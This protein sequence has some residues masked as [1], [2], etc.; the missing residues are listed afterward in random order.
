MA[1]ISVRVSK[2]EQFAS[3]SSV[4]TPLCNTGGVSGISRPRGLTKTQDPAPQATSIDTF[5]I[6]AL[7]KVT[8]IKTLLYNLIP[9][10]EFHRRE[11]PKNYEFGEQFVLN[12]EILGWIGFG[13]GS[14]RIFLY[15]TG[16]GCRFF[17]KQGFENIERA[18]KNLTGARYT[19]V[20]IA[21]DT[22]EGEVDSRSIL[23]AYD[24]GLFRCGRSKK[25]PQ[26]KIITSYDSDGTLLG[27]TIYIG[28]DRATKR[29]RCY[30]KGLQIFG[31]TPKEIVNKGAV[32]D[33]F[34]GLSGCAS[35]VGKDWVEK[36]SGWFR[37][38][39]QYRHDKNRPLPLNILTTSDSHFA[40]AYPI[41]A[42]LLPGAQ[43]TRP[44]YLPRESEASLLKHVLACR[45]S[46]GGLLRTLSDHGL[47]SDQI[48]NLLM[49][50]KPS[51]SLRRAGIDNIENL[52][53]TALGLIAG[54]DL[55]G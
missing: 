11:P 35:E 41:C 1:T 47:D 3:S 17:A 7:V 53:G 49:T 20:D 29:A 42:S 54:G 36:L 46:Y 14:A 15:I 18:I 31:K 9:D 55:R 13:G 10:V 2:A 37:I 24:E 22:H 25:N 39:I 26:K 34:K 8:E 43:A 19:R 30:E 4:D 6:T 27:N 48:V 21:S 33:I 50:D 32:C 16:G 44:Q 45:N 51:K 38:E 40:G 28:A 23:K 52:Y 5:S 12:G